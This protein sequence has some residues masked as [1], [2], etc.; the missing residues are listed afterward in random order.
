M[1]GVNYV[2][3]GLRQTLRCLAKG[4]TN[5]PRKP[6]NCRLWNPRNCN[7]STFFGLNCSG[8]NMLLFPY[9][10]LL[11]RQPITSDWALSILRAR[12]AVV[13][14]CTTKGPLE[15]VKKV[16]ALPPHP[17]TTYSWIW[18]RSLKAFLYFRER[19]ARYKRRRNIWKISTLFLVGVA[20]RLN[21]SI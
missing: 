8:A 18:R 14:K 1:E 19:V 11:K 9:L 20:T 17:L 21:K 16:T 13:Q 12:C 2:F 3:L 5:V 4:K 15:R 10:R 7:L 6:K